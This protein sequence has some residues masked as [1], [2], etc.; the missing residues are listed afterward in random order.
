MTWNIFTAVIRSPRNFKVV[1]Y[2]LSVIIFEVNIGAEQKQA[3]GYWQRFVWILKFFIALT[4]TVHRSFSVPG[5][6]GKIIRC[7]SQLVPDFGVKVK[8]SEFKSPQVK[9]LQ[10]LSKIATYSRQDRNICLIRLVVLK[11]PGFQWRKYG[12]PTAVQHSLRKQPRCVRF[13]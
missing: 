10:Y 9:L 7:G 13:F 6:Q 8:R 3:L 4:L 12:M 5:K 1:F 11:R 2:N